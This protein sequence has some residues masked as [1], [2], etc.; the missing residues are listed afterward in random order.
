MMINTRQRATA[1]AALF[2]GAALMS[3][4]CSDDRESTQSSLNRSMDKM[5]AATERA[6]ATAV[7]AVDDAAIT[8]R[9]KTAVLAEPGL[10]SL[11]IGVDTFNG[12]V[13]L[14]G[15]VDTPDLKDRAAGIAHSVDGVRSVVDNLAVKSTG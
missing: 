14:S 8:A 1:L 11:Q 9:V 6:A 12:V 10:K 3:A 4:G 5:A 13:T 7:N 15:T 2:A